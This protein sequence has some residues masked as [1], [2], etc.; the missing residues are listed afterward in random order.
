[1]SAVMGCSSVQR[2]T[3]LAVAHKNV[4]TPGRVRF[5]ARSA[6]LNLVTAASAPRS[7]QSKGCAVS[8]FFVLPVNWANGRVPSIDL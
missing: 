6:T 5:L 8:F 4:C 1:M 2:L 3:A 7:A